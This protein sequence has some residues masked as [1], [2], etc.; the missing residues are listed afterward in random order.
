MYFLGHKLF[1]QNQD[2]TEIDNT[3]LEWYKRYKKEDE[4]PQK[5]ILEIWRVQLSEFWQSPHL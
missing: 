2:V 1:I 3:L 5:L 4:Y